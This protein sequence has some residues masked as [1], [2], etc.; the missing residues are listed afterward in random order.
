MDTLGLCFSTVD[1][2]EGMTAFTEKHK[3]SFIGK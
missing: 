1:Q 3:A 2:K